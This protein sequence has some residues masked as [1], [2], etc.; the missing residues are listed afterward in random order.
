MVSDPGQYRW[1]SYRHNGLGQTDNRI[2]EHPF[3]L[4]LGQDEASR[5]TTY[6][7]VFRSQID[8]EA[9]SNIRLAISQGQPLGNERF[10]ELICAATGMRRVQGRRGRPAKLEESK[11]EGRDEQTGFGF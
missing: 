4:A 1:S 10:K 11:G 9:I 5:Q 3:Y 6:R 8:D 7:A 2:S